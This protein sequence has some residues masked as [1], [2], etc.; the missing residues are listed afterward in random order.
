MA[1]EFRSR[2]GI[3]QHD[4]QPAADDVTLLAGRAVR[5]PAL[6]RRRRRA[7]RGV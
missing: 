4:E 2:D 3:R 5:A 1:G 7:L 6:A